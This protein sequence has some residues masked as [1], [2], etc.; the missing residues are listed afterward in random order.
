MNKTRDHSKLLNDLGAQ[1]ER[2]APR[3][4]ELSQRAKQSMVDGGSHSVRLM[5]PFPPRICSARGAWVCD[6][7]GH[8]ILDFWQGHYANILGHNPEIITS[9]LTQALGEHSGLQTGFTDQLQIETAEILCR[10]TGADQARL[11]TSGTLATMYAIMLARAFTG[12]SLVMKVG[13]G[14]HGGQP[15]GFKGVNWSPGGLDRVETAG[16]PDSIFGEIVITRFND[17]QRLRDDLQQYGDRLACFILE[18]LI[19]SNGFIP[20]KREYLQ[21]ARE[22][23]QQYGV[24]LILDEV[25]TG[26]RFRAG[27]MGALYGVRPDLATFGKVM[28]GGMPVSAVAGRADIMKLVGRETPRKVRFSGGTFSGHPLSLLAAKTMMDYLVAH[29]DEVYL[30]LAE[31]GAQTRRA[32]E[33]AFAEEGILARCTG[34]DR[35]ALPGSSLA[36]LVF[37]NAAD[38]ALDSPDVVQDPANCDMVLSE[39]ALQLALLLENVY[40]FHGLGS[41]SAAHTAADIARLGDACRAIARRFKAYL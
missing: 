28:G 14:W 3:S 21:L 41:L 36:S 10:Q 40:V 25:I 26:F 2:Y 31:L 22:L 6:E 27:D 23:T 5:Q 38:I 24:V 13:G 11:T 16:L 19:G 37:P 4:A 15:W 18:P 34:Y 35:E 7:D 29:E 20:A 32:V 9:A 12:R 39:V 33:A 30:R 8:S 17:P 1:Y